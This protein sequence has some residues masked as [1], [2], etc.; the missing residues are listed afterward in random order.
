M[1]NTEKCSGC[2]TMAET[3]CSLC[4]AKLC[5]DHAFNGSVDTTICPTCCDE[6]RATTKCAKLEKLE[7]LIREHVDHYRSLEP[8]SPAR[9]NPFLKAIHAQFSGL[10]KE[11]GLE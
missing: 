9:A 6:K 7:Q 11:A 5:T 2:Q 3:E 1:S 4:K 8:D 10:L